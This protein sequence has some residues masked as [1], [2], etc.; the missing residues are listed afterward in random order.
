[1]TRSNIS[2]LIS[3]EISSTTLGRKPAFCWVNEHLPQVYGLE[4]TVQGGLTVDIV[5]KWKNKFGI[6]PP[7]TS[8]PVEHVAGKKGP[9][10][11]ELKLGEFDPWHNARVS[12]ATLICLAALLVA[13]VVAGIPLSTP[14]SSICKCWCN[15]MH[16][17]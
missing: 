1:V 16:W 14:T 11:R 4:S 6:R 9:E 7:R 8:P 5:K 13:Q 12:V 2:F 15:A 3:T 10:K 17:G